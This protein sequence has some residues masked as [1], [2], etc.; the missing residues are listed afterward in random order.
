M[1]PFLSLFGAT[2]ERQRRIGVATF[3]GENPKDSSRQN[4]VRAFL[5]KVFLGIN[6]DSRTELNRSNH[7]E[8][9]IPL[10][11]VKPL[12]P[13]IPYELIVAMNEEGV[14]GIT[15]ASGQQKIPW[16][17]PEDLQHFKEKTSGHI[18]VMGRKTFYSLPN[19]PLPNR[20]H[21][22]ITRTP[23]MSLYQ[24]V[25]YA[26][27]DDCYDLLSKLRVVSPHKKVFICGGADIYRMFLDKCQRFHITIVQQKAVVSEGDRLTSFSYSVD[28]FLE[29]FE[30]GPSTPVLTS[31]TGIKYEFWEF[32]VA[33]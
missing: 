24:S 3:S 27:L 14:I 2:P 7:K 21:I 12:E 26:S 31:K 4:G 30:T 33:E 15:D 20:L 5:L 19:G 1:M 32:T 28:T 8:K 18:V 22:V 10:E 16:H 23:K 6:Q 13:D 9:V 25:I 11:P 17:L 29:K